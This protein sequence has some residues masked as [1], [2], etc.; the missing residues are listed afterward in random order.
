[1]S[2]PTAIPAAKHDLLC[3]SS[4]ING[5]GCGGGGADDA[6]GTIDA[7]SSLVVQSAVPL[8]KMPPDVVRLSMVYNYPDAPTRPKPLSRAPRIFG[9]ARRGVFDKATNN[10]ASADGSNQNGGSLLKRFDIAVGRYGWG[11]GDVDCAVRASP[12]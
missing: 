10:I 2:Y 5:F 1:M 11:A 8:A 6:A 12:R 7:L 3:S 9:L 4:I